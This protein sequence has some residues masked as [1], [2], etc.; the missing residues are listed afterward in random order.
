M[1]LKCILEL[2]DEKI[3]EYNSIFENLKEKYGVGEY[4]NFIKN[5][6]CENSLFEEYRIESKY[7]RKIYTGKIKEGIELTELE[8][9]MICDNGFSYFGGSSIIRKDRTFRVEIFID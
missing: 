9:S 7:S 2:D 5:T 8:L 1:N 6:D 4:K 3:K